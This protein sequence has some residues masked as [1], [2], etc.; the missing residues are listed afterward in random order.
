MTKQT[1]NID[2]LQ[3]KAWFNLVESARNEARMIRKLLDKNGRFEERSDM[4][5]A[6]PKPVEREVA[7]SETIPDAVE[8]GG[9]LSVVN[10]NP[11]NLEWETIPAPKNPKGPY[12]RHPFT[13]QNVEST[14][15]YHNLRNAI[16]AVQKTGKHVLGHKES[17]CYYWLS[18][19]T[20][21][22]MRRV[23]KY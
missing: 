11:A 20:N 7:E 17:G 6:V 16:L 4:A 13:G 9:A 10:W 8:I 1:I 15:D 19:D 21:V 2:E 18:E 23:S 22:I 3:M 12:E 14:R 5:K